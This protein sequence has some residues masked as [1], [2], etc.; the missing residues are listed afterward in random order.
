MAIGSTDWSV[1]RQVSVR[2]L[3]GRIGEL[4]WSGLIDPYL[5]NEELRIA[6]I[7]QDTCAHWSTGS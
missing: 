2:A 7:V 6:V 3:Q 5:T 4:S 1:N